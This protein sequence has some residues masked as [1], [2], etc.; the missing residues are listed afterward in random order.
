MK[1]KLIAKEL[2]D[3]ESRVRAINKER[4]ALIETTVTGCNHPVDDVREL[5]YTETGAK[6]WLI[7]TQC[8]YTEEGWYCGYKKLRHAEF[9]GV[10]TIKI[11]DWIA[12]STIRVPQSY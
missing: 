1:P 12:I 3:M 7:C 4:A 8:G 2:E 5:P 6:P 10:Q 9:K 11:K